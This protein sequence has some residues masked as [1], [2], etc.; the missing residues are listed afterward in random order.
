MQPR[1]MDLGIVQRKAQLIGDM[2]HLKQHKDHRHHQQNDAGHGTGKTC[3]QRG[4]EGHQLVGVHTLQHALRGHMQIQK[5]YHLLQIQNLARQLL[6]VF[7]QHGHE[8]S[9]G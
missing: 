2:T 5:R 8:F 4:C 9:N 3:H 6:V 1:N 7:W